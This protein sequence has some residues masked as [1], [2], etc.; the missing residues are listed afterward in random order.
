MWHTSIAQGGHMPITIWQDKSTTHGWKCSTNKV[1]E[2]TCE[3]PACSLHHENHSHQQHVWALGEWPCMSVKE[4]IPKST[5]KAT[6]K[7]V[8]SPTPY[9]KFVATQSRQ[10]P[11][12]TSTSPPLRSTYMLGVEWSAHVSDLLIH[13]PQGTPLKTSATLSTTNIYES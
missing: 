13:V 12:S 9:N 3:S 5:T 6:I 10:V 8:D 2:E 4:P 11:T 1:L 7:L